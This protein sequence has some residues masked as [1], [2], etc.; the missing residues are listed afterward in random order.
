VLEQIADLNFEV[1]VLFEIKLIKKIG[2]IMINLSLLFILLFLLLCYLLYV[3]IWGYIASL[4]LM[5]LLNI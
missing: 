4:I 5:L 3:I 2:L 1:Q